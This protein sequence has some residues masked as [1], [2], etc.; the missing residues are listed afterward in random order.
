V[1]SRR[2]TRRAVLVGGGA[3]LAG[4]TMLRFAIPAE[5]FPARS[6]DE[7]VPW[8]APRPGEPPADQVGQQL[9][10]EKLDSW[11][12][13]SDRF[14]WIA[15]YGKPA[16]AAAEYRL[17]V[18][19]LVRKPLTLSLADLRARPRKEV[20]FTIECSGNHGFP[21]VTGLVGNGTWTGTP[22]AP[23]LQEAGLL[24]GTKDVVFWGAD[25]GEETVR[26]LKVTEQFARSLA[27]ADA[28]NPDNLLA[29]ELNGQPLPVNNGFPLRLIAPG[30]YGVA[31]VKW[32]RR[33]E[34]R[35]S[36]YEGRF[37][38]RD[39][40]T[41]REEQ[42]DGKTVALFTSVGRARLKSAPA[43]VTVKDGA[44]RIIGAAWGAPVARV[45][46]RVDDGPWTAATL[47]EGAGSRYAWAFWY[48]D[49]PNA[50]P[51]QHTVTSRAIDTDG[52]V[53]ASPTDPLIANKKTYWESSGQITR[54]VLTGGAGA[55]P[56]PGWEAEFERVQGRKPSPADRAER[57]WSLEFLRAN[58]RAPNR[59]EWE[60]R[61]R[62]T[63]PS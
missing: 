16:I 48:L 47:E 26:D 20:T 30:W 43:K 31:N 49:W 23:L 38:G 24:E 15:H 1:S 22:L 4:L 17:E 3:A 18:G 32:L 7:V 29:Y 21:V 25:T 57:A 61:Y 52:N 39:Y 53:Q 14:F 40:V 42:R 10:W 5:A 41:V 55:S 6:G 9:D 56:E 11:I 59:A 13:P 62:E 2:A 45:E 60:A 51:G 63:H 28:L 50:A 37:M 35:D 27:P 46:V 8:R 34:A 44:H 33:I 36:Q 19:G 58:G 54:R 12:T